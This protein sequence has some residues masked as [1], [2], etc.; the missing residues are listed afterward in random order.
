MIQIQWYNLSQILLTSWP[1]H[2]ALS[3]FKP[4]LIYNLSIPSPYCHSLPSLSTLTLYY[5]PYSILNT[6]LLSL[7]PLFLNSILSISYQMNLIISSLPLSILYCWFLNYV[8]STLSSIHNLLHSIFL[9]F[10]HKILILSLYY[11]RLLKYSL[12]YLSVLI[13]FLLLCKHSHPILRSN[14]LMNLKLLIYHLF[15]ILSYSLHFHETI[16]FLLI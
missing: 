1:I 10:N 14:N 2:Y 5:T 16:M 13:K 11:H 3:I 7:S 6:P 15:N 12:L 8:L 4:L 9:L